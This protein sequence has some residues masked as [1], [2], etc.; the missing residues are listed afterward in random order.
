MR[1]KPKSIFVSVFFLAAVFLIGALLGCQQEVRY[2]PSEISGYPEATQKLIREGK[3]AMGMTPDEVRY[4]WGAPSEVNILPPTS[5]GKSRQ[6]WV[7]KDTLS[8]SKTSLFF[9]DGRITE[10]TSSG[11]SSRKFVSPSTESK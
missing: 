10:M 6:E 11:I 8:L 2:S 5:D 1:A 3:V 7:Y 9:T 4:A